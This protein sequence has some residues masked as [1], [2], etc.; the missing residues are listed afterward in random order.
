PCLPDDLDR[1]LARL[2]TNTIDPHPPAAL[3]AREL[4]TPAGLSQ[5]VLRDSRAAR[6]QAALAL[7]EHALDLRIPV[8]DA[9]AYRVVAAASGYARAVPD[10][11]SPLQKLD[12][13]VAHYADPGLET[14]DLRQTKTVNALLQD[15]IDVSALN[16]RINLVRL[17]LASRQ[18]VVD[19]AVLAILTDEHTGQ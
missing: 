15:L 3:S 16:A 13:R 9:G 6:L 5:A 17:D 7:I 10:R 18:A 12:I 8:A 11:I 1:V 2:I 19:A 14:L 4:R